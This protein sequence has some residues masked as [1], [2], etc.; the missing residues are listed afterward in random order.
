MW[1]LSH[2]QQFSLTIATQEGQVTVGGCMCCRIAQSV[3]VSEWQLTDRMQFQRLSDRLG[4]VI[5]TNVSL[6]LSLLGMLHCLREAIKKFSAWP[7]SVQNKIKIEFVSYSTKAHNTTCTIWL[8]CCKY[9]VHF[10]GRR[11]FAFDMEENKVTQCNKMTILWFFRS[12]ACFV[13]LT[14]NRS[15][16]CTFH[17]E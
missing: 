7:S 12:I 2:T 8:L 17:P 3:S 1:R 13:V 5:R 4:L 11:L 15:C 6:R 9:F 14:Q 10:S 16:G